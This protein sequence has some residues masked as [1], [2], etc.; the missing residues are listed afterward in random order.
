[1]LDGATT[2]TIGASHR[3]AT[4]AALGDI[5]RAAL[6]LERRV[7]DESGRRGLRVHELAV[8]ATCG[9]AEVYATC[10]RERV[11][12]ALEAIGEEVF[13]PGLIGAAYQRTGTDAVRHAARVAAG[14]DSL[15]VGEHEIAG[16]LARALRGGVRLAGE[17]PGLEEVAMVAATAS[18]R[19]RTETGIGRGA[20]S[21]SSAAVDI[22]AERLGDSRADGR[23]WWVR[24]GRDSRRAE[25]SSRRA[26]PP[27][28]SRTARSPALAE[29][30]ARWGAC[31]PRWKSCRSGSPTWTSP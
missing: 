29:W 16:Q 28:P 8:L 10:E 23:S 11:A 1:M 22:A 18:R 24:E 4:G 31:P 15:V 25:R 13:G 20:A 7:R 17:G 2:L 12:E 6:G 14:L 3:T 30:R 21:V 27:S 5:T 9:R 19:T 26:L